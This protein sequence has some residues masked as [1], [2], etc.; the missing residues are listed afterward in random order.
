M[1]PLFWTLD[2]CGIQNVYVTV[3]S[4]TIYKKNRLMSPDSRNVQLDDNPIPP[5]NTK[6]L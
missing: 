2:I 6:K 1:V 5:K 4:Y 3:T